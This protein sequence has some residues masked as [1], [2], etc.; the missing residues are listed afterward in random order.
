MFYFTWRVRRNCYISVCSKWDAFK[1]TANCSCHGAFSSLCPWTLVHVLYSVGAAETNQLQITFRL[2]IKR[3]CMTDGGKFSWPR[4]RRFIHA[5]SINPAHGAWLKAAAVNRC[6]RNNSIHRI[7]HIQRCNLPTHYASL[8]PNISPLVEC[9]YRCKLCSMTW[10]SNW[11]MWLG[12]SVYTI[13]MCHCYYA[14]GIQ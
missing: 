13:E 3:I 11:L 10:T 1:S 5:I 7:F 6:N 12:P 8:I 2:S 4:V 14:D 9:F